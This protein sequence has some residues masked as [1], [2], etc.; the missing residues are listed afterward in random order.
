[1]NKYQM[2]TVSKLNHWNAMF[3]VVYLY[4]AINIYIYIA[5]I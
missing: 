4:T 3:P 5:H 2:V 1:M